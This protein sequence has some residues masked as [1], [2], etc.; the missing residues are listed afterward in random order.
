VAL[1]LLI[2]DVAAACPMCAG[3]EGGGIGYFIVL[4]SMITLPF[5]VTF[6]VWQVIKRV[7]P[8][9]EDTA[10]GTL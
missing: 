1:V 10:E 2:A 9:L 8:D 4:A 3:R 7:S 6:V 5:I